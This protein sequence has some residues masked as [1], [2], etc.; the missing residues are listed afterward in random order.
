MSFGIEATNTGGQVL[1]SSEF[2]NLHFKYKKTS[3]DYVDSNSNGLFGGCKVMRYRFYLSET[4]VPFFHVPSGHSCAVTAVKS[5]STGVWDI[6]LVTN[7][8]NPEV[9][10]FATEAVVIPGETHGLQVFNS[11]SQVTFDSRA[12]P[13]LV[14]GLITIS[15]PGQPSSSYSSSGFEADGCATGVG[16]YSNSF[17]PNNTTWYNP[18]LPSKPLMFFSSTAQAERE[19]H[20]QKEEDECDGFWLKGDCVGFRRNYDYDSWYWAFYRNTIRWSGSSIGSTWCVAA[21]GCHWEYNKDSYA[22]GISNGGSSSSGG[23]WP[24][25][26]E[27]INTFNNTVIIGNAAYYD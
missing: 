13:L 23:A 11:S 15:Q 4:P 10:V 21:W 20:V 18:G 7:G 24:Y 26:N 17:T 27:T 1:I 6:E 19:V 5:V 16:T 12:A 9:Y 14:T 8:V 22:F 25:S 2:K 3:P